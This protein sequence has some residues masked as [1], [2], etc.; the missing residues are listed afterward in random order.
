MSAMSKMLVAGITDIGCVRSANED[1]IFFAVD[2]ESSLMVAVVADGMGGHAGGAV[3]SSMA[4]SV[5]RDSWAARSDKLLDHQWLLEN[6]SHANELIW[7]RAVADPGLAQMGTTIVAV[8][9]HERVLHIA[10]VGDS[11]CYRLKDNSLDQL[12]S[13]HSVVQDMVNKGLMT[14]EEAERSPIK[15]YLTRSVGTAPEI[16]IDI[17]SFTVLEGEKLLICSDGLTNMLSDSEIMELMIASRNPSLISDELLSNALQ[18]GAFDNISV[19]V[20]SL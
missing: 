5:F 8:L 9:V 3:A 13:D 15:N 12:T 11:R 16:E 17:K 6:I 4:T 20:C 10:H 2:N 14:R 7:Q 1:S 19:V 18:R